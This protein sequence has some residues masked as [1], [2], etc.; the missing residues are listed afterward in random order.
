MD[1]NNRNNMQQCSA[2]LASSRNWGGAQNGANSGTAAE[3]E[4][5]TPPGVNER[6][7]PLGVNERRRGM[8]SGRPS[9]GRGPYGSPAPRQGSVSRANP[10][11]R[12]D[13]ERPAGHT[14]QD[15]ASGFARLH[16]GSHAF[17]PR[18]QEARSP[19]DDRS[20]RS[21]RRSEGPSPDRHSAE[22]PSR[23]RYPSQRASDRSRP[24][25]RVSDHPRPSGTSR[26]P[27]TA[28]NQQFSQHD[29][30][31]QQFSQHDTERRT[32]DRRAGA[33]P[34]SGS[35]A[36]MNHSRDPHAAMGLAHGPRAAMSPSRSPR[37]SGSPR[38]G[39]GPR[40]S[41]GPRI[42][43]SPRTPQFRTG[44][45]ARSPRSFSRS[46]RRTGHSYATSNRI[47]TR[48]R[49]ADFLRSPLIVTCLIAI[50]VIGFGA[51]GIISAT[52]RHAA[53]V[54]AQEQKDAQKKELAARIVHP[55]QL[56][57][58]L[59]PA[60]TPRAEWKQ[61]TLPHLYQTDPA[62]A[63]QPYAG[64][65]VRVNACGPTCLTMVYVCL[66]GRTDMDPARMSAFADQNNF[67]PTGATEWSFMTSGAN[68]LGIQSTQIHPTR[69]SIENALAGGRPVICSVHPGDFTSVGHF[70]V[71]G[72]I[73]D[74]GM[75]EV[76]D[77]N[78][79]FN[80]A[81]RWPIQ[82]ILNQTKACWSFWV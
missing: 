43:G 6:H 46:P 56:G 68:M 77:P 80:S 25:E 29:T 41:G 50:L 73:D 14:T 31:N 39:G 40:T 57:T 18:A 32:N 30:N 12:S 11:L 67:A 45:L 75:V 69:E 70:I 81:Q 7:V 34:P 51:F 38:T 62:W 72:G 26:D 37:A 33:T 35:R 54:A 63:D 5:H 71:L 13:D 58:T 16:N 52:Q 28:G 61:G 9:D 82:R 19:R 22:I 49:P 48:S 2:R 1:A 60:S 27:H 47:F 17:P 44:S 53:E 24:T 78:S 59:L 3:R 42:G 15:R 8:G 76:F 79:P 4:R 10:F 55:T 65:T 21:Q 74:Q 23:D 64:G 66:T 20:T 36:V